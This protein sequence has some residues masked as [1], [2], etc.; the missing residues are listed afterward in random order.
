MFAHCFRFPFTTA[1]A[2]FALV[3]AGCVSVH[4]DAVRVDSDARRWTLKVQDSS[5][6]KAQACLQA[7]N[8]ATAAAANVRGTQLRGQPVLDEQWE[9][10]KSADR[11]MQAACGEI[12]K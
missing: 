2:P 6:P 10:L 7:A 9:T 1:L 5:D 11:E 8:A 3:L 4:I 12:P